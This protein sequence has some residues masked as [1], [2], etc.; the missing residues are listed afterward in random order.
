[1]SP[2]D[3]LHHLESVV[4]RLEGDYKLVATLAREHLEQAGRLA[5]ELLVDLDSPAAAILARRPEELEATPAEELDR[6]GIPADLVGQILAAHRAAA[7]HEAERVGLSA[8][9][10][11]AR[12][13]YDN[14]RQHAANQGIPL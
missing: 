10:R 3:R 7:R 11:D 5:A 12:L 13:L 6:A 2:A 1:M 4:R 9:L 8:R 14:C